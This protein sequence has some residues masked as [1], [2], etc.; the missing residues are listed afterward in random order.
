M[1]KK[2]K[3][4]VLYKFGTVQEQFF[5]SG[6]NMRKD[7]EEFKNELE[8]LKKEKKIQNN[9][10][11][12]EEK[13]KQ[14][15]LKDERIMEILDKTELIHVK[16]YSKTCKRRCNAEFF[17]FKKNFALVKEEF[18]T[19]LSDLKEPMMNETLFIKD[20][21]KCPICYNNKK[22]KHTNNIYYA[23]FRKELV[24]LN[25]EIN[26]NNLFKKEKNIILLKREVIKKKENTKI[27]DEI[28]LR[29]K[30]ET[31]QNIVLTNEITE[32]DDYLGFEII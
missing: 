25:K 22:N 28:C 26:K 12:L 11:K 5:L 23:N 32:D 4:R 18:R 27:I 3:G 31:L 1:S 16:C 7:T 6:E 8:I 17:A 19:A 29:E 14:K 20:R 30:F 2:F 13:Y 15:R 24:C 21:F 10:K 9:I